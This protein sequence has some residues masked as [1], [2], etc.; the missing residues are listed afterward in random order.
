MQTSGQYIYA[1]A[2]N[3]VKNAFGPIGIQGKEVHVVCSGQIAAVLSDFSEKRLRPERR[4]LAAH[5]AVIKKI[6]EEETVLPMAFG[7]LA[8]DM[9]HVMTI[10]KNNESI[11]RDELD[12]VR[13][14]VEMGVRV[15][16]DLPNVFEYY[17]NKHHELTQ[18][19]DRILTLQH[20]SSQLDKIE[21][22][23][24]FERILNEERERHT[25]YVKKVLK[26][27]CDD[28]IENPPRDEREVMHLACLIK[29]EN[30]KKFEEAI[31]EAAKL[32][33]NDFTFDFNGPWAPHHFISMNIEA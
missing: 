33:N 5:N 13:G 24:V 7:T 20:A 14:K 8:D 22:G 18:L 31:F 15:G 32:F 10:L 19:R 30:Q 11:F 4:N 1:I 25:S 29:R 12:Q 17:V 2:D 9:D 21:L 3:S 6:M 16:V 23:R 28:I 27:Y 26:P